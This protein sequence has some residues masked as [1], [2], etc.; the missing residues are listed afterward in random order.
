MG[1]WLVEGAEGAQ[2]NSDDFEIGQQ[3]RC[4]D[5]ET[6]LQPTRSY[7]AD[8]VGTVIKIFPRSRPDN[9][10]CGQINK[11]KVLWGKRNGR[12]KEKEMTMHP[13]DLEIIGVDS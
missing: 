2:V 4:L 10:Y 6:F 11:V 9:F 5:T 7:L 3:V 1:R 13:R 8:R 12:G